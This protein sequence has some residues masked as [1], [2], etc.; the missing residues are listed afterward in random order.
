VLFAYV[1]ASR[2]VDHFAL[3][4][5]LKETTGQQRNRRYRYEP[6]LALFDATPIGD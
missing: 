4:A 5:L 1:T 6:C 3:P 2:L